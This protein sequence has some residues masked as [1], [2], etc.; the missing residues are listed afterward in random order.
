MPN[1]H[2]GPPPPRG[3]GESNL[4][5]GC[6]KLVASLRR[7]YLCEPCNLLARD[8]AKTLESAAYPSYFAPASP[9][10]GLQ[11]DY[12]DLLARQIALA[13]ARPGPEDKPLT[14]NQMRDFFAEV[15]RLVAV[16][17]RAPAPERRVDPTALA[18][19]KQYA[20]A[21]FGR[22]VVPLLFK[23]FVDRNVDAVLN[24]NSVEAL[25]AFEQHFEA[26]VAYSEG[27]LKEPGR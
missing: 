7:G 18:K 23:K 20:H 8:G 14:K 11:K 21:R 17:G 9:L 5:S 3:G 6:C 26:V 24:L 4:C 13:F 19:L 27:V 10:A 15:R 1:D 16:V 2:R 12:V 22:R 25:K